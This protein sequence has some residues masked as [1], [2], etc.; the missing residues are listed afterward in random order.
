VAVSGNIL[1]ELLVRIVADSRGLKS[2]FREAVDEA[3]KADRSIGGVAKSIGSS[4]VSAG[5]AAVIFGAAIT[6]TGLAIGTALVV[7]SA[8]AIDEMA[9]LSD[10]LDA[11]IEGLY[12]LKVVADLA[13]SSIEEVGQSIGFLQRNISEAANGSETASK[14]F[15]QLGINVEAIS[16]LK[17]DEQ[18][19]VMADALN[20][21]ENQ[22][23]RTRLSMELLG[24]GG[25]KLFSVM[26]EGS[27]GFRKAREQAEAFGLTISRLDARKVEDMNDA[28]TKIDLLKEGF[29]NK[30]TA[31][32]APFI[33]TLVNGFSEGIVKAGG[34]ET[35]VHSLV[36]SMFEGIKIASD[37]WKILSTV[38]DALRIPIDIIGVA[39][40]T[41]MNAVAMA[42]TG[43]KEIGIALG[44]SL[45]ETAKAIGYG[46]G[47]LWGQMKKGFYTVVEFVGR[48]VR[49]MIEMLEKPARLISDD[50]GDAIQAA[51][52]KVQLATGTLK[53]EADKS[54]SDSAE[55][56]IVAAQRAGNAWVDNIAKMDLSTGVFDDLMDASIDNL[57]DSFKRLYNDFTTPLPST[58]IDIW[59]ENALANV[60][61]VSAAIQNA[62]GPTI[63]PKTENKK[64]HKDSDEVNK[65]AEDRQK[66]LDTLREKLATETEI[67]E[68]EYARRMALLNGMKDEE[69]AFDGERYELQQRAEKEHQDRMRSI[70]TDALQKRLQ[71]TSTILGNM[72]QLMQSH[73]KKMFEV[74]KVAAIANAVVATAQGM[75]QALKDV[76]FPLNLAAAA[77][78]GAAGAVQI[79]NIRS[80]S[81]GGGS[82]AGGVKSVGPGAGG[83]VPPGGTPGGGPVKSPQTVKNITIIG[84]SL[85]QSATRQMVEELNEAGDD[86]AVIKVTQRRR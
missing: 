27:E 38:I 11:N 12:G 36:D 46:F 31:E 56:Y 52:Y 77:A 66:E 1:Q 64:G 30:L 71:M 26:E 2:G 83:V 21:V 43:V 55:A 86:G 84:S 50:L 72:S 25:A 37:A 67:E 76:P 73:S 48:G 15:A 47:A 23:E 57:L 74:G 35:A 61:T 7:K 42:I 81:F 14:A 65:A 53:A 18:F 4:L 20:R 32:L 28:F 29:F 22:S 41:T 10:R 17:G 45:I 62:A 49:E 3:K 69:F 59:R 13:G 39:F 6:A 75:A 85:N 24:R 58:G 34:M 70:T 68:A 51:A 16:K 8:Q 33:S 82:A 78:V 9:K 44:L 79:Q 19:A 5:K 80:T 40:Y 63:D 60:A 54:A